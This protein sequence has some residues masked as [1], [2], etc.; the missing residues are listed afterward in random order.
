MIV[1]EMI[2]L[3]ATFKYTQVNETNPN[4]CLAHQVVANYKEFYMRRSKSSDLSTWRN[5]E[6]F[7]K[8]VDPSTKATLFY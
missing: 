6:Q 2:P 3:T 5:N 4:A 8:V 7:R 1:K